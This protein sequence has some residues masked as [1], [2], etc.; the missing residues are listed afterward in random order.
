MNLTVWKNFGY[1]FTANTA[2]IFDRGKIMFT[3]HD[4]NGR[5]RRMSLE[6]FEDEKFALLPVWKRVLE[7]INYEGAV[8]LARLA[9][10]PLEYNVMMRYWK[11]IHK[12]KYSRNKIPD[13]K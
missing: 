2:K 8:V 12:Q 13:R 10:N 11:I 6:E 5:P 4:I 7:N 9:V 1:D 3:V